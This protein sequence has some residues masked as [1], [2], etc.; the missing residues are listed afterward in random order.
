MSHA[1]GNKIREFVFYTPVN[2]SVQNFMSKIKLFYNLIYVKNHVF[3]R[4]KV[5]GSQ[6][7][8]SLFPAMKSALKERWYDELECHKPTQSWP[9][10]YPPVSHPVTTNHLIHAEE[11]EYVVLTLGF[12]SQ[13]KQAEAFMKVASAQTVVPCTPSTRMWG[14]GTPSPGPATSSGAA[15]KFLALSPGDSRELGWRGL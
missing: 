9:P 7:D 15:P 12:S 14:T 3:G 4:K 13:A 11:G 1:Q 6:K 5:P 2:T 8:L 10:I